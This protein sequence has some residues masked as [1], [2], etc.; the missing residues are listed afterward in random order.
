MSQVRVQPLPCTDARV[1][2]IY[3]LHSA[4]ANSGTTDEGALPFVPPQWRP[5]NE[6]VPQIPGTF[7]VRC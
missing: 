1:G 7:P 2:V 3:D 5:F 6:H 4:H